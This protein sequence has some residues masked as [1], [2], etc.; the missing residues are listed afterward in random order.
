M[1]HCSPAHQQTQ[2]AEVSWRLE[3][4]QDA[5]TVLGPHRHSDTAGVEQVESVGLGALL[6]DDAPGWE[7]DFVQDTDQAGK[8]YAFQGGEGGHRPKKRLA[9]Q[10]VFGNVHQISVS[11]DT[12][13]WTMETSNRSRDGPLTC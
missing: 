13:A 11:K 7:S 5:I 9:G 4:G 3:L 10:D 1:V 2:L 8:L 6:D 12:L